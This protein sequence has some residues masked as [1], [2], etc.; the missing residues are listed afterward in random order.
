MRQGPGSPRLP[1]N[2]GPRL[3][4]LVDDLRDRWL[5]EGSFPVYGAAAMIEGD[6]TV[7]LAR[8]TWRA[9]IA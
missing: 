3:W 6:G 4:D 2:G 5:A 1:A 9:T 8:G 7:R